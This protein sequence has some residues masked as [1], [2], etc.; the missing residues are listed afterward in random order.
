MR[1]SDKL[2]RENGKSVYL[3]KEGAFWIAYEQSAYILSQYKTLKA[4]KKFIKT[5]DAEIVSVGFPEVTLALFY[6]HLGLPSF[7][8]DAVIELKA[9]NAADENLF[10]SW[11]NA[12]PLYIKPQNNIHKTETENSRE[13]SILKMLLDYPLGERTPIDALLFVKE[14]KSLAESY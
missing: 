3:Y 9:E 5:V 12:L 8:S 14:L 7:Q 1:I 4:S 6:S 11:K 2:S 10:Q 13:S